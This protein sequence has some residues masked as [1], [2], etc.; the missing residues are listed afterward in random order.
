[1][2]IAVFEADLTSKQVAITMAQLS[3]T[4]RDVAPKQA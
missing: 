1:M 2:P 4:N 3:T